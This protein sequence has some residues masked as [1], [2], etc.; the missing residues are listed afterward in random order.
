ME[1]L[2]TESLN[3]GIAPITIEEFIEELRQ[4]AREIDET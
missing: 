2:F 1:E 3:S 4:I